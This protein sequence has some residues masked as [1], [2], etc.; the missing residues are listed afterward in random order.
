MTQMETYKQIVDRELQQITDRW[1]NTPLEKAMAYSVA[2]GGKRLRPILC[3][4]GFDLVKKKTDWQAITAD[5][6]A[7]VLPMAAGIELIHTYSLIQ[8][9]LPLLDDDDMR[10]GK[11]TNH[12]IFGEIGALL[13]S[14]GLLT[15]AIRM[16]IKQPDLNQ[17]NWEKRRQAVLKIFMAIGE[18]G[19]LWGQWLDLSAEGKIKNEGETKLNQQWTKE[20]WLKEMHRHKTGD[21]INASLVSGAIMGGGN[22]AQITAA[23]EFSIKL[24][25]SFQ[26]IDDILDA[27]LSS[28]E[29]GK[30]AGKD[31]SAGKLT[32]PA[33]F[34][35][36]KSWQLAEEATL[37]GIEAL[38]KEFGAEKATFLKS[39]AEKQLRR[40]N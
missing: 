35:L 32:Y 29:L 7:E 25:L 13:A 38:E 11:A 36:E 17:N 24:G 40:K 19:M 15:V 28:E 5:A 39:V 20:K 37:E 22:A 26:I 10:R 6:Y 4:A 21:L 8:D 27:T 23:E 9:D 33:L 14:D 34:G 30:T 3:L 12:V 18:Q 2:A 31:Q 1:Q 16:M